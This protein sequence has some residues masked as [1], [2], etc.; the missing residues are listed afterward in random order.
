MAV[1]ARPANPPRARG[2]WLLGSAL[3]LQ[4][5]QI[6]VYERA[7]RE[8]GDVVRLVVGPP[9]LR[10]TFYCVFHPDGVQRVLATEDERYPKSDR[11]N[12]E[13]AAVVGP[14]LMTSVGE[15]WR[16]ARRLLQPLFTPKQV[17]T[18]VGLMVEEANAVADRW[19]V[20]GVVDAHAAMTQL[21]LRV[22]GRAIFGDDVDK[23]EPVVRS[24]FPVV[25]RYHY[26]RVVAPWP[27]AGR[28]R[29]VAAERALYDVVDRMIARRRK[30]G[31]DGDDLLSRLIR[32]G[33]AGGVDEQQIRGEALVFLLAG[34]ETTASALTFALYELGRHE[35][36][37][38]RVRD[39]VDSILAYRPP[40]FEQVPELPRTAMV[41]KE[42]MRLY[43]PV[44]A[45]TRVALE[46]DEILGYRIPAQSLIV[47]PA[48]AIHRH[49]D[50]W[51][52]PELFDPERFTSEREAARHR[53]AYLP[54]GR[55]PRT[56]IGSHFAMLEAVIALAV[57]LQRFRFHASGD[58]ELN[59]AGISVRPKRA[60]PIRL[61]A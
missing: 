41:V 60:V 38:E 28:R 31:S 6:R 26:R 12:L 20:G 39:E 50:F 7:M 58:V 59:T 56:C 61:S 48:W 4:R 9:G 27:T 13:L 5:S 46:E 35:D 32:A 15:E 37:Q 49:A 34:H 29:S 3:A 53:Y 44:Y 22:V 36:E 25:A 19:T 54:F 47:L 18:Y 57:L 23:A 14:T 21:A 45:L 11:F 17:A 8:H 24:A 2:N 30:T 42:T 52:D 33:D 43:P 51:D 40:T 55:G 16:D 10:Y 1:A